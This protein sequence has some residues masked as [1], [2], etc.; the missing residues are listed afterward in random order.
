MIIKRFEV[1]IT[2]EGSNKL[3]TLDHC[4][5][6]VASPLPHQLQHVVQEDIYANDKQLFYQ[7]QEKKMNECH[8]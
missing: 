6:L 7:T 2:L 8:F 4:L 5:Y 1:I 3:Q